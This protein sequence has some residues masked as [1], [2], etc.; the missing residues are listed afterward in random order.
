M[1]KV[2]A[3]VEYGDRFVLIRP[4]A[5]A[6]IGTRGQVTMRCR[7]GLSGRPQVRVKFNGIPGEPFIDFPTSDLDFD[8]PGQREA[9]AEVLGQYNLFNG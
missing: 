8:P 4:T 3:E 7:D 6:P 1:E 5:G 2:F 9:E